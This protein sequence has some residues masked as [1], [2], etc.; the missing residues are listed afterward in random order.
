MLRSREGGVDDAGVGLLGAGWPVLD[1]VFAVADNA[2][3]T[4][5]LMFQLSG[6]SPATTRTATWPD[7]SGTVALLE[8]ANVFTANQE[9]LKT[10]PV[11]ILDQ[12]AG[13]TAY[14]S[15]QEANTARAL[16]GYSGVNNQQFSD[17]KQVGD[18]WGWTLNS[19]ERMKLTDTGKL[20]LSPDG[21]YQ[22]T[23]RVN[24]SDGTARIQGGVVGGATGYGAWW[25][26]NVTP[27]DTNYMLAGDGANATIVNCD[28]GD[29]IGL[30][31]AGTNVLQ[32][33]STVLF[34][35]S[36][37]AIDF[38]T[39]SGNRLKNAY[40]SGNCEAANKVWAASSTAT[41]NDGSFTGQKMA[42]G[43]NAASGYG[44]LESLSAGVAWK[45]IRYY[46][47]NHNWFV[48]GT[49][50]LD[51]S[52]TVLGPTNDGGLDLGTSSLGFQDAWLSR[53]GY[54]D[55]KFVA[56][57]SGATANDGSFSGFAVAFGSNSAGE[58][59][60]IESLSA[61][62][63]WKDLRLYG[64]TVSSYINGGLSFQIDASGNVLV[65]GAAPG[66]SAAGAVVVLNGTAPTGNA[67]NAFQMYSATGLPKFRTSGGDIIILQKATALTTAL[68][69]VT[70][71]APGTPDY[72]IAALTNVAPYGFASQ[73]EGHTVLSVIA[74]LQA[75]VNELETKLQAA[76]MLA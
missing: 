8:V 17:L 61:G 32:L 5:I 47:A 55:N 19:L 62:V 14:V 60:F 72:A 70:F 2:D 25:G 69:T 57:G 35:T 28:T 37:N 48:S 50:E 53:N 30:A 41:V 4:K 9:I 27:D 64:A 45:D 26:G 73:D 1:D 22:D 13:S 12:D 10:L 18:T 33:N 63:A 59:G 34:A 7:A 42:M 11:F 38:G 49:Q 54:A 6:I 24:H 44:F 52:A 16:V 65:N 68:T 75:R 67:T 29:Y 66:A 20:S 46:G 23:F 43:S 40:F 31:I 3:P 71:T 21:T 74:N 51:L 58:Y 76:G 15:F 56:R 36:D 39:S